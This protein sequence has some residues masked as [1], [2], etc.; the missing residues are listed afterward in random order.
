MQRDRR[1]ALLPP[2]REVPTASQLALLERLQQGGAPA[3]RTEQ[4]A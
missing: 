4:K 2:A 1:L 3:L